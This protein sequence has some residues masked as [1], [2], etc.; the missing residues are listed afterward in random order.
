[1]SNLYIWCYWTR[2]QQAWLNVESAEAFTNDSRTSTSGRSEE[3]RGIDE[4]PE[5]VF[6][7]QPC[8]PYQM[9]LIGCM[10][11]KAKSASLCWVS[12]ERS[13]D[14]VIGGSAWRGLYNTWMD[15]KWPYVRHADLSWLYWYRSRFCWGILLAW[16]CWDWIEVAGPRKHKSALIIYFFRFTSAQNSCPE[17][18]KNIYI[19]KEIIYIYI[20]MVHKWHSDFPA[21]HKFLPTPV[22][23]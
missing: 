6:F 22:A 23:M 18:L 17:K 16:F 21:V 8:T 5:S 14:S 19:K 20:Y 2:T 1:M 13:Q 12:S 10:S 11:T 3:H 4:G 7:K 9:W 15:V